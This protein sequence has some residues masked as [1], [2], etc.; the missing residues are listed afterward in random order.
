MK[1][2][3]QPKQSRN[4]VDL[5]L[6]KG[7]ASPLGVQALIELIS[8]GFDA[9]EVRKLSGFLRLKP[10]GMAPLLGISTPTLTRRMKAGKLSAPESDRLTRYARLAGMAACILGSADAARTWLRTPQFG[11]GGEVPL[12][13]AHT[14]I[15]AREVENL[16][17]RIEYGVYS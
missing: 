17:G 3:K 16:L 5:L 6:K 7:S 4:V 11:L 2:L 15:G 8:A 14:E 9:D 10:E 13:F 12:D 1:A